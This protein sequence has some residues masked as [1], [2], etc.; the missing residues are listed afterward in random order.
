MSR[1][2]GSKGGNHSVSRRDWYNKIGRIEA[3]LKEDQDKIHL[4]KGEAPEAI[5]EMAVAKE[6]EIKYVPH[7]IGDR[8]NGQ[9]TDLI[10][11][12]TRYDAKIKIYYNAFRPPLNVML[13]VPKREI[14]QIYFIPGEG[15]GFRAVESDPKG[16]RPRIHIAKDYVG[17]GAAP[18]L[19]V[20]GHSELEL[21]WE[22]FKIREEKI[23][24]H[25]RQPLPWSLKD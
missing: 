6:A 24:R 20:Q 25:L 13:Y 1:S 4:A 19:G 9:K 18:W 15:G 12:P 17:L 16:H 7:E 21:V 2:E 8:P 23:T 22:L 3:L 5:E 10:I 14:S 11:L